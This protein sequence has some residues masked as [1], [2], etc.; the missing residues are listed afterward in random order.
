[1]RV[2][3]GSAKGRR[4]RAPRGRGVR[5]TAD[6]VKEAL[7]NVL[8]V[9][10]GAWRILDLFAGTGALGIEALSR[11]AQEVLFVERDP[12][13]VAALDENLRVCGFSNR[14]RVLRVE[15]LRF[16]SG[17]GSPASF[18]GIFADPPYEKGLAGACVERIDGGAW[19]AKGGLLVVEHSRR[20]PLPD[21][22]G[23]LLRVD[24]RTYG[25]TRISMYGWPEPGCEP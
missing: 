5:P 12:R 19:L 7:F 17:A 23:R 9:E 13:C 10:W 11:G 22:C 8:R 3:S 18:D 20:E 25:D 6:R 4:L 2:I 14:G 21:H 1:M 16:L 15:A 24:E